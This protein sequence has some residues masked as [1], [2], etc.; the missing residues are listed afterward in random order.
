MLLPYELPV[1]TKMLFGGAVGAGSPGIL[2]KPGSLWFVVTA[3]LL[4]VHEEID[5]APGGEISAVRRAV[6]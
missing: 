1:P 6:L 2:S 3:A 4:D 5:A